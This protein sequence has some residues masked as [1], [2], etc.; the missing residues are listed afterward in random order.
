MY[1]ESDNRDSRDK[2]GNLTFLRHNERL[3]VI[4][5][6][7]VFDLEKNEEVLIKECFKI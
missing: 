1:N 7:V 3:E 6:K 4:K 2:K 5:N